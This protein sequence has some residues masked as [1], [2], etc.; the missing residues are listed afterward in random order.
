VVG[1]APLDAEM[2]E[3]RVDHAGMLPFAVRSRLP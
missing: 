1:Q 2:I 3:V